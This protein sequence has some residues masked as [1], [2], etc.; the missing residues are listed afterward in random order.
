MKNER[1]FWEN[2]FAASNPDWKTALGTE[3]PLGQVSDCETFLYIVDTKTGWITGAA[4][5]A[6][7]FLNLKN[8]LP[9]V[10]RKTGLSLGDISSVAAQQAVKAAIEKAPS[11]SPSALRA[12]N[13][14]AYALVGTQTFDAV[15]RVTGGLKGHWAYLVYTMRDGSLMGRPAYASDPSNTF[16]S[17]A[18][19]HFLIEQT[20]ARDLSANTLVGQQMVASGGAELHESMRPEAARDDGQV[21]RG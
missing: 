15:R 2:V 16:L 14:V 17:A 13:G 21:P 11:N 6:E 8:T 1:Q 18:D 4:T 9:D 5:T 19:L 10:S 3:M 7:C 12:I 20:I